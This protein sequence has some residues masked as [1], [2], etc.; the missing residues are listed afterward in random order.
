MFKQSWSNLTIALQEQR[1]LVLY[2]EPN[3][4][5]NPWNIW[6]NCDGFS[7]N[8][9]TWATILGIGKDSHATWAKRPI[10]CFNYTI[11]LYTMG[12]DNGRQASIFSSHTMNRCQW[13]RS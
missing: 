7:E 5:N 2:M 4:E 12:Y 9:S 1:D 13:H 10:V 8:I 6:Q 11:L 3:C